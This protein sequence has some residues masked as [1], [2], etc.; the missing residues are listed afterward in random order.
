[1]L[2]PCR[3]TLRPGSREELLPELDEA[4]PCLTD[5]YGLYAGEM[6][7]WHWHQGVELFYVESGCVEYVAPSERTVFTGGMGGMINANSPHMAE[8]V[9]EGVQRSHLFDPLLISGSAGSRIEKRYVLPL[10]A[11]PQV[12]MIALEP[13]NPAH[14]R[15]LELLKE[16]FG[17]NAEQPGYELKLRAMLSE[18]W[19][20]M[21]QIAG[22]RLSRT[23]K[24]SR[25]SDQLKLMMVHI[26]E[27]YGEKI[28][29]RSLARIAMTSERACYSLFREHLH[30][31][32][33]EYVETHRVRM[34]CRM[35]VWTS[36]PV[37]AIGEACGLGRSSRFSQTFRKHMNCT[38]LQYRKL[39]ALP[40]DPA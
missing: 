30:T 13:E 34:A 1:M 28:N 8:G 40:R 20:E 32:P 9:R 4:F 3:V 17:L 21:L 25:E 26:H 36:E 19:L 16:S 37:A 27:H 11:A 31:S 18:I 14:A 15:A 38:P 33:M 6:A 7:P 2:K 39:R 10:T 23:Q 12:E 29:V 5:R 24:G 35:L 22:P